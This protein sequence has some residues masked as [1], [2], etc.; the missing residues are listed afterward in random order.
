MTSTSTPAE[1]GEQTPTQPPSR[2]HVSSRLSIANFSGIAIFL[3]IFAVFAIQIPETFLTLGTWRTIGVTQAVAGALALGL[4]FCLA[5]GVYDLSVAQNLGLSAIICGALMTSGPHWSPPLA[6]VA[7]LACG[8]AIGVMNGLLVS[9]VGLDSFIAT[10]GT[11]SLLLAVVELI[12]D[13]AYFGPFD[14][15]FTAL[16]AQEIAGVPIMVV[17]VLI[18]GLVIWWLL[19]HTPLGRK[20]YA[21]GA[22]P[23]AARLSG[24]RT[25]H[26][27]FWTLV[28]SGLISSAAGIMVASNFNA[29]SQTIG[30]Q[31][32]LPAFS[33]AFLG[34]TQIKPGRVNVWGTIVGLVLLGAGVQGIQL[35]GASLWV[36]NMFNGLALII[37]VGASQQIEKRQKARA[38]K[39]VG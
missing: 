10:L 6:I 2:R 20:A 39:T 33:A 14:E 18:L 37:A 23:E 19:E 16:T 5:A 7:T 30:P 9:V 8:I 35:M 3:V 25:K 24:I 1:E 34:A 27:V 15:S 29:V 22:N 13:G 12:A 28:A 38:H 17:Y 21:T 4:L 11:S 26:V 31:Y 36:T 32:L